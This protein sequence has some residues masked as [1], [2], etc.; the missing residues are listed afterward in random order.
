MSKSAFAAAIFVV[1][2]AC[3]F[4]LLAAASS[5]SSRLLSPPDSAEYLTI[6]RNVAAGHFFS[7]DTSPPYRP[8]VRRTP[9]YPSLLAGVLLIPNGNVWLA[10]LV[11]VVASAATVAIAFLIA[12][13]LFGPAA[14]RVGSLLLAVDVTS[15]SYSVLILTEA[16]FTLLVVA[17][18][19]VLL[20]RPLRPSV[21]LRGGLLFGC[22]ALCRPAGVFLAPASLPVCAWRHAGRRHILR[23]YAS[24]NAAF[25]AI[26]FVWVARNAMVA[27]TPTISSIASVN[28]YF[29]RAA[30]VEALLEGRDVE[31]VRAAWERRFES[32][33]NQWTESAKQ[34]WMMQHAREVIARHPF[35]YL[36]TTLDGLVSMMQSDPLELRRVLDVRVGT[37]A[38]RAVSL[39]SSVQL[40][41]MYP[42]AILGLLTTTRDPERRQAAFVPLTFIAYFILVAGPEA[43]SRF[44]VP[45]MPFVAMLSGV[46]IVELVARIR[47]GDV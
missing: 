38:F 5:D 41:V 1:A 32:M 21:G 24:L 22:A 26:V 10:S 15:I 23:D 47:R 7:S 27:G 44:R 6:A 11:G 18:V 30:A 20:R 4:A 46:G 39:A 37:A 29:H 3:R 28:L 40:W 9:I 45:M 2:L 31:S 42:T 36:R 16:F 25:L 19:A 8:D 34:E 43:Y 33:S 35:L 17:G 13:R 14:A 12:W